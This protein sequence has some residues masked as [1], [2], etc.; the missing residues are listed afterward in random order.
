MIAAV[1]NVLSTEDIAV[2]MDG[3]RQPMAVSGPFPT[4]EAAEESFERYW[5][6]ILGHDDD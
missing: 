3:G 1:S 4:R 5:E 6:M 2:V